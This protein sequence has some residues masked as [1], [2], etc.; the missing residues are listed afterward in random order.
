MN[1]HS[2]AIMVLLF[3]V[4][5]NLAAGQQNPPE[6][7]GTTTPAEERSVPAPALSGLMGV[8]SGAAEDTSD[9]L[10]TIPA[11]LGGRG[12]PLT[13]SSE[14]TSNMIRGGVNVGA[15]YDDNALLSPG[16]G[17][18]NISFSVYPSI[19]IE[20]SRARLRWDLG[21]AAGLTVNQ[22]LSNQDRGSHSLDFSS[23]FRLS[24]HV[25]LRVAEAFSLTTGFFNGSNP[26]SDLGGG[27]PNVSLVTPLSSQRSSLTTVET[28]YHFALNDLVGASGSFYDMHFSD[29]PAGTALVDTRT[30]TGSVFWLHRIFGRDWMG[31]SYRF[32]RL[33]FAP[34]PGESLVHTLQLVNTLDLPGGFSFSGFIGPDYSDSKS[35]SGQPPT[36]VESS[37]WSMTGGFIVGWQSTHTNISGGYSRAVSDGG[38]VLGAVRAQNVHA[39]VR[40]ELF[41]SWAIGAGATHGTNGSLATFLPGATS[42]DVTSFRAT[43]GRKLGK[44]LG[45]EVGYSHD[46][47]DQAGLATPGTAHRNRVF[48][49]LSYQWAR[50][51]GN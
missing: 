2:L 27:G 9:T 33:T 45:G 21:Y 8:D 6:S 20:Q 43:M 34:T 29:V 25:S 15:A 30:E 36:S 18:S 24:P 50:P 1:F 3:G 40:R 51:L 38:G 19:A 14:A 17:E 39:E 44:S 11:L 16:N 22:R 7:G 10:P 35:Q 42:A 37:G 12:M 48:V 5:D 47:Q 26:G 41:S 49:T 4:L 13:L 28:H 46:M 31:P 23:E 32:Q